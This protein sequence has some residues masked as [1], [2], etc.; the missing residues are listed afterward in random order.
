VHLLVVLYLVNLQN[1]RCKNK[2]TSWSCLFSYPNKIK[3]SY[4]P[5][6]VHIFFSV[7]VCNRPLPITITT[8]RKVSQPQERLTWWIYCVLFRYTTQ[9][10]DNCLHV[11]S[12][13]TLQEIRLDLFIITTAAH[14]VHQGSATFWH[15]RATFD[16]HSKT[17]AATG[18]HW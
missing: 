6:R 8:W 17:M 15:L 16:A 2:D 12:A 3:S 10:T 5:N 7:F 9:Y 4:F 18:S 13:N 1:A 11:F 14:D